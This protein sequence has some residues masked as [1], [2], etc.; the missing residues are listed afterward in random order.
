MGVTQYPRTRDH[1]SVIPV[2]TISL[3]TL[4]DT[5][6]S[7][8]QISMRCLATIVLLCGA[9]LA[10]KPAAAPAY[11]APAAP[12]PDNYGAPAAPVAAPANDD[13]G[14]PAAPVQSGGDSY[15]SPAAPVQTNTDSYGA[16]PGCSSQQPRILL[17]L[18]SCP[19]P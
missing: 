6:S 1:H 17:L 14:A 19:R 13:Y 15:G 5:H 9:A 7:I 10:D 16:P 4:L 18:L 8:I 3:F 11:A 12:A 2:S